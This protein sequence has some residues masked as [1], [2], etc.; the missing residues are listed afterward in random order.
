MSVSFRATPLSAA[1]AG[2]RTTAVARRGGGVRVM[3]ADKEAVP[4]AQAF[5]MSQVNKVAKRK[6]FAESMAFGGWAPEVIN[7]RAAQL[8][9]VAGVGA[10][11][12]TGETLPAQFHDHIFALVFASTLIA[13]A[14]FM[15]DVQARKYSAEPESKG[16]FGTFSPGKEML[17]GRLAMV[18]L[19]ATLLLEQSG[20]P[21]FFH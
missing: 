8:A 11:L 15:P 21:F 5:K 12:A 19:A 4:A 20:T 2:R 1:P 10:E 3:A 18:G 13:L 7:G 17:H 14:S 16:A 6:G 9:F